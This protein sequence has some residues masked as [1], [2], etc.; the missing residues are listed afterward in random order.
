MQLQQIERGEYSAEAFMNDIV[1]FIKN[2]CKKYG[3]V[4]T[5]AVFAVTLEEISSCPNCGKPVKK[6]KFGF[7]C[8][9][10]CGMNIAKVYGKEL[11]ETQ[12]KKLLDGKEISYT[13]NGR[14]TVVLPKAVKNEYNGKT[15]FQWETK[16]G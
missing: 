11:T 3:T 16:K 2:I 12:L 1:S 4:D 10:K 8:T 14:K 7:H 9:G 15:Y 5:N 6:G 13:A